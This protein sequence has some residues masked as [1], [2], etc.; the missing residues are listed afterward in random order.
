[1]AV[2]LKKKKY[3]VI[4]Y[5]QSPSLY[6]LSHILGTIFDILSCDSHIYQEI[7]YIYLQIMS[8]TN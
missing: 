4:D 6:C 1:M 8:R 7:Y 3:I 2:I 5:S